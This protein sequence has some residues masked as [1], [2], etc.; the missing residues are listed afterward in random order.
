MSWYLEHVNYIPISVHTVDSY[1]EKIDSLEK[2]ISTHELES[3][4]N[5]F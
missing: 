4:A 5:R 2:S 1:K 3:K